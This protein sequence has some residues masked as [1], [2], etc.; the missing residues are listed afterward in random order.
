MV[1]QRGYHTQLSFYWNTLYAY[2]ELADAV[3]SQLTCKNEANQAASECITENT[4]PEGETREN[5][6]ALKAL[7]RSTSS[8]FDDHSCCLWVGVA[9][10][11]LLI[12]RRIGGH[13]GHN[14]NSFKFSL[15]SY[16]TAYG[17]MQHKR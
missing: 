10:L 4:T 14:D 5:N 12:G 15:H 6:V 2:K 16:N 3:V 9:L 1:G 13:G 11:R 17:T 7:D 8:S